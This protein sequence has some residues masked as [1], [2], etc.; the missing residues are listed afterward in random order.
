MGLCEPRGF[1]L[2][3]DINFH[4][5]IFRL[6]D[7]ELSLGW[8]GDQVVRGRSFVVVVSA[9]EHLAQL[10]L[11]RA[12]PFQFLQP[13]V[14]FPH[15]EG[16]GGKRAARPFLHGLVLRMFQVLED[17]EQVGVAPNAATTFR[18]TGAGAIEAE[19]GGGGSGGGRQ[20]FLHRDFVLPGI[21]EVVFVPE[22]VLRARSDLPE[23][24]LARVE[25]F[26]IALILA[27]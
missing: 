14:G 6:I 23:R 10:S 20:D 26:R 27:K 19:R 12:R 25:D 9:H 1:A 2:Q 22:G 11:S 16:N 7:E 15:I 5:S 3:P 8:V 21:A 24:E 4:L 17:L 18:R 13:E